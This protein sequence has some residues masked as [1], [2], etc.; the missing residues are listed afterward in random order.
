MPA[1]ET[2]V[3][4]VSPTPAPAAPTPSPS[5][6]PATP[7]PSGSDDPFERELESKIGGGEPASKTPEPAKPVEAKKPEV[8]PAAPAAAKPAEKPVEPTKGGPKELREELERVRTE[9]KT[10]AGK[11]SE[12]ESKIADYER[13]GKDAESLKARLEQIEKAHSESQAE[14]RALKQEASPE[15][16]KQYD[17]PLGRALQDT[18]EVV[19]TMTRVDDQKAD[20]DRDVLPLFH[21]SKQNYG[22]AYA[23]ARE[24]FGDDQA[25]AI[26]QHV[27]ELRRLQSSRDRAF[28]DEKKGWAEKQK[29]DEG[30]R[31]Q[32]REQQTALWKQVS[33]DLKNTVEDYK[34]PVDDAELATARATGLSLFDE[35][36]KSQQEHLV[37]S[38]HIRHRLGAYE[39]QKLQIARHTA[40]IAELEAKL[41]ETKT[42]QPGADPQRP[43]G[44]AVAQPEESWE[45]AARSGKWKT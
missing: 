24:M 39:A 20:F 26:M 32:D 5:P 14:L 29:A 1:L 45:D 25:P 19:G 6:A 30:R 8:K 16:K 18:V 13:R 23:Q 21:L 33:E 10:H 9:A 36:P 3:A 17:E 7:Q 2:P 42:R 38:A 15:F 40:R 37:K 22:R 4:P 31:V 43:G 41:E 34:D 12:L 28:A 11:V 44:G 35:K 27:S